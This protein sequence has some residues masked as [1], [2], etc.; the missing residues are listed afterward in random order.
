MAYAYLF[1]LRYFTLLLLTLLT[2]LPYGN[3]YNAKITQNHA[4]IQNGF[5]NDQKYTLV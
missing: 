1:T 2:Y 5:F 3:S 4:K